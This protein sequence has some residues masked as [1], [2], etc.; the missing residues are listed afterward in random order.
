MT[1]GS[2]SILKFYD[3]VNQLL[4]PKHRWKSSGFDLSDKAHKVLCCRLPHIL[5]NSKGLLSSGHLKLL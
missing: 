4:M 5:V 3:P 2:F 1:S